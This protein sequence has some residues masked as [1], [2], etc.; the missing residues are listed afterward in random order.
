MQAGN[1]QLD[2]VR[3]DGVEVLDQA[4]VAGHRSSISSA[5]ADQQSNI[6]PFVHGDRLSAPL[7]A[8]GLQPNVMGGGVPGDETHRRDEAESGSRQRPHGSV[9]RPG[10][11][12]GQIRKGVVELLRVLNRPVGIGQQA[13]WSVGWR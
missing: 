4:V 8:C 13:V 3:A 6:D 12:G 5:M 9:G 2:A 1:R 11:R 7:V 10:K